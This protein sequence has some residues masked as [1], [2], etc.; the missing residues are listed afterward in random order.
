V[1]FYVVEKLADGRRIIATHTT[2]DGADS[3]RSVLILQ[4]RNRADDLIV[5]EDEAEGEDTGA[6]GALRPSSSAPES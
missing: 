1:P 5:L 3:H 2:R 6:E 4:G